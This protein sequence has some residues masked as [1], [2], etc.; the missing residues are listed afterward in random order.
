MCHFKDGPPGN[1]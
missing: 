1:H